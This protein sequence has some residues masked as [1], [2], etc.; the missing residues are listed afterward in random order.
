[1]SRLVS[2][3]AVAFPSISVWPLVILYVM[4]LWQL[5]AGQTPPPALPSTPVTPVPTSPLPTPVQKMQVGSFLISSTDFP[6]DTRAVSCPNASGEIAFVNEPSRG[7]FLWSQG[8]VN[9]VAVENDLKPDGWE[10]VDYP[11]YLS[12]N[13]AG[14]IA[15]G[16]RAYKERRQ[17]SH[18]YT[19]GILPSTWDTIFLGSS[20][21]LA[22]IQEAPEEITVSDTIFLGSSGTLRKVATTGDSSPIGSTFSVI[23][24]QVFLNARDQ[25]LFAASIGAPDDAPDQGGLFLASKDTIAKV[26][27]LGDTSPLGGTF[28]YILGGIVGGMVMPFSFSLNNQ[29]HVAFVGM[30]EGGTAPMGVFVAADGVIRKVIAVGESLPTMGKFKAL[31]FPTLNDVGNVAFFASREGYARGGIFTSSSTTLTKIVVTD[32]PA[33]NG[34]QFD[35]LDAPPAL[36]NKGQVAFGAKMT[37][38]KKGIFLA[39]GGVIQKV[40]VD[41]DPAP[42]GRTFTFPRGG[43]YDSTPMGYCLDDSGQVAFHSEQGLFL[44]SPIK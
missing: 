24:P 17:L 40:I 37:D 11:F 14:K 16:T 8:I 6:P 5:A 28:S 18:L 1:M 29:G 10:E 31:A 4:T 44:A 19:P 32:D 30:V 2:V 35:A 34:K 22:K 36:N 25:L 3:L 9:T 26:I 20:G 13:T 23:L 27:A 21:T 33:P 15:F 39:S 41:G 43:P 38:G 7:I 12:L 42:A